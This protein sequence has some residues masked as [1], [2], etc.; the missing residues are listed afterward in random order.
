MAKENFN[1]EIRDGLVKA[2]REMI[3][4]EKGLS[5]SFALAVYHKWQTAYDQ[6]QMPEEERITKEQADILFQICL[7]L[8]DQ[9]D[10]M[11]ENIDELVSHKGEKGCAPD[12]YIN[13]VS[14][15]LSLFDINE[16]PEDAGE[17]ERWID[18]SNRAIHRY[19][20]AYI[21]LC[22]RCICED[23]T[24]AAEI[25]D[26]MAEDDV[27]DPWHNCTDHHATYQ[28]VK[29]NYGLNSSDYTQFEDN[30]DA[31]GEDPDYSEETAREMMKDISSIM[32]KVLRMFC[33]TTLS[34][35]KSEEE[36]KAFRT[37]L[38]AMID[39]PQHKEQMEIFFT[40]GVVFIGLCP[41]DAD[42]FEKLQ[43]HEACVGLFEAWYKCFAG[44]P[45]KEYFEPLSDDDK[46]VVR[47]AFLGGL[48]YT[49][50]KNA[51]SEDGDFIQQGCMYKP[52]GEQ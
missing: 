20:V 42:L 50:T 9:L 28:Y 21:G 3:D 22:V 7:C 37:R 35:C 29:D 8:G 52:F 51:V 11:K 48:L 39:D 44:A 2:M 38:D 43:T 14:N 18:V 16:K 23:I 40:L 27:T 47:V 15:I 26:I 25:A 30:L 32:P 12:F 31:I 17:D 41:Q 34:G 5:I 45:L 46:R 6:E 36:Q 24:T 13:M 33:G 4:S 49:I 1:T 10:K 19:L